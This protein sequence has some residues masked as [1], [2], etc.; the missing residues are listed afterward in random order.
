MVR[1]CS[2]CSPASHPPFIPTVR[3]SALAGLF[4][5]AALMAGAQRIQGFSTQ[6]PVTAQEKASLYPVVAPDL[7]KA[8]AVGFNDDT[9]SDKDVRSE[10]ANSCRF[11]AIHLG[12][13][14]RA[15]VVTWSVG[16]VNANLI[17]V[18]MRQNEVWH[19]L[20]AGSGY[21]PELISDSRPIP[22]LIFGGTA[23]ACDGIYSRYR[24]KN[25]RYQPNACNREVDAG[26][27]KCAIHS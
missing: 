7:K 1:H 5:F 8:I 13:L 9:L 15:I 18:Y 19:L 14:G 4:L 12:T 27:G 10:Y 25:G 23:G 6:S 17:N 11:E 20:I 16:G 24:Y 21:G 2:T 26:G 3:I 22:D